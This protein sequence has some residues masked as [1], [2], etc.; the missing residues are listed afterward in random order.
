M[1]VNYI[2][3]K[4]LPLCHSIEKLFQTIIEGVEKNGVEKKEYENP[5][6]LTIL[7]MLKS[8][9]YFRSIKGDINHITGDIHWLAI[10][11]NPNKTILTIHDLVGLKNNKGLKKIIYFL[12]WVYLPILRCKYITTISEKS[13]KEITDIL[14]WAEKKIKVIY[15]CLTL[16]YEEKYVQ[17]NNPKPI[18]VTIGSTINKNLDKIFQA[19]AGKEI[20]L[21]SISKL[22]SAQLQFLKNNNFDFINA[23]GVSNLDLL[24]YYKQADILCFPSTY[25]GFGLPILEAQAQNCAVITSNISPMKEVASISAVLVNPESVQEI[26][27]AIDKLIYDHELKQKLILNGKENVKKYLPENISKQYIDLYK[28][29]IIKSNAVFF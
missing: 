12:F 14:P 20:K 5:Y 21:I 8:V 7:G 17:K 9:L 26:S 22:S 1:L 16:D 29:I 6:P 28:S 3:R 24:N 2:F 25:E 27:E 11:L 15:N 10:F 19:C 4:K 18:I 23:T 13:K